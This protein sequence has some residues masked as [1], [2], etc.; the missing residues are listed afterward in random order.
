MFLYAYQLLYPEPPVC[1]CVPPLFLT[2]YYDCLCN[3]NGHF[4]LTILVGCKLTNI[5]Q[6]TLNSRK[7]RFEEAKAATVWIEAL[8]YVHY[9]LFLD[10]D[11]GNTYATNHIWGLGI[12][13]CYLLFGS[14]ALNGKADI[15]CYDEMASNQKQSQKNKTKWKWMGVVFQQRHGN[16]PRLATIRL[17]DWWIMIMRYR[18]KKEILKKVMSISPIEDYRRNTEQADE[19]EK[20]EEED[21]NERNIVH[22]LHLHKKCWKSPENLEEYNNYPV[23]CGA[24][25]HV[26][27]Y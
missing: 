27:H 3:R 17:T 11:K 15:H 26:K 22:W 20:R 19:E 12:I 6:T 23:P 14:P 25:G 13:L 21:G 1:K 4:V 18:I 5:V 7:G 16:C 10:H 2:G 24:W 8:D 9:K